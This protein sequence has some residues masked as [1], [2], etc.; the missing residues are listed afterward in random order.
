MGNFSSW[1]MTSLKYRPISLCKAILM[2]THFEDPFCFCPFLILFKKREKAHHCDLVVAF[3][4]MAGADWLTGARAGAGAGTG[5]LLNLLPV[6]HL[7]F[8]F[9]FLSPLF[10][11]LCISDLSDLLSRW[12][13]DVSP[14][15]SH[16]RLGGHPQVLRGGHALSLDPLD[17]IDGVRF[18]LQ[19][20]WILASSVFIGRILPGWM[21]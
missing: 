3:F 8:V 2:K 19:V 10:H 1:G 21:R 16:Q 7:L 13:P 14:S 18:L 5:A 11:C 12:W 17:V 4:Q 9:W 6:L 15:L 20:T